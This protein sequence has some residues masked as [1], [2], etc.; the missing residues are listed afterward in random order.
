MSTDVVPALSPDGD[1]LESKEGLVSGD[2]LASGEGLLGE[3][4]VLPEGLSHVY[5]ERAAKG[6]SP[7]A[8]SAA[9]SNEKPMPCRVHQ[10]LI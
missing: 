6:G 3:E 4:G 1:G 8:D 7:K 2:G 9:C 5:M 10:V